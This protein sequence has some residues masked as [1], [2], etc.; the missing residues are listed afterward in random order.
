MIHLLGLVP[1]LLGVALHAAASRRFEDRGT[2]RAALGQPSD[3][4]TDRVY[5]VTRNPM[6]LAGL[7]I[8]GGAGVILGAAAPFVVV[9]LFGAWVRNAYI[10]R[11]EEMLQ[12]VF[13]DRY[14]AYRSRVRRWI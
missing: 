3:L 11:E 2:T 10:L 1:I 12:D 8:L 13:G 14:L 6:Y 7:L 9:P 5:G 4:V